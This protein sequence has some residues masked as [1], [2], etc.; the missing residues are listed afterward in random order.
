MSRPADR[1][2]GSDGVDQGGAATWQVH[3]NT[4]IDMTPAR[5]QV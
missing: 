5:A 1:I 3:A 2:N 4:V